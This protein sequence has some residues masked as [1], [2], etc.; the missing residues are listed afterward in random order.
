MVD[1]SWWALTCDIKISPL[2][3]NS[4]AS[5]PDLLVLLFQ[6]FLFQAPDHLAGPLTLPISL[7]SNLKSLF[8]TY[9][10]DDEVYHP[11]FYLLGNF[12]SLVFFMATPKKSNSAFGDHLSLHANDEADSTMN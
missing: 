9:K 5:T 7:Y 1:D 8:S 12:P 6:S 3:A 4:L 11:M 2:H 10:V